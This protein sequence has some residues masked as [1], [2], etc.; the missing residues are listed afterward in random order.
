MVPMHQA[1]ELNANQPYQKPPA[2]KFVEK[3]LYILDQHI[4]IAA[5]GDLP[6]LGVGIKVRIPDL[7]SHAGGQP[8]GGTQFKGKLLGHGHQDCFNFMMSVVSSE[9]VCSVEMDLLSE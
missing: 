9:K 5:I 2:I 7:D 1:T 4:I 8:L 3:P 6:L